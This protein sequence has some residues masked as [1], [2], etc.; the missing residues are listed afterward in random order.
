MKGAGRA[1]A[2][3]LSLFVMFC[4]CHVCRLTVARMHKSLEP[5]LGA[6]LIWLILACVY[7]CFIRELGNGFL[8]RDLAI[9]TGCLRCLHWM[10]MLQ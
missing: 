7:I 6:P 10:L 8:Y 9:S 4:S 5:A 2:D 3:M 1:R